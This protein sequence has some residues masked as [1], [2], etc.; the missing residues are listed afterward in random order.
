M[1]NIVKGT[2]SAYDGLSRKTSTSVYFTIDTRKI[3]IGTYLLLK[4][5]VFKYFT[6][7]KEDSI[8]ITIVGINGITIIDLNDFQAVQDFQKT[9]ESALVYAYR[10][11][12]FITVESITSDLLISE[13]FRNAYCVYYGFKVG[14]EEGDISSTLF[15]DSVNG[16]TYPAN[17]SIAVINDGTLEN[18]IYKF[19]VL[20]EE[21]GSS[22]GGSGD[23]IPIV[24]DAV[25]GDI[26]I[27]N[28]NGGISDS[29][30]T[31][32]VS[33]PADAVFSKE[34]FVCNYDH[35]HNTMDKTISEINTARS[36]GMTVICNYGDNTYYYMYG[37]STSCVFRTILNL[38]NSMS[39]NYLK[40]VNGA[41]STG[42]ESW[43]SKAN[44]VANA[45][46]GH[47]AGL[48]SNGYLTD[49]GYSPSDFQ[50]PSD[51]PRV[52]IPSIDGTYVQMT[53]DEIAGLRIGDII[54]HC[55]ENYN[56]NLDLY[57]DFYVSR[58]IEN[59][60]IEAVYVD[61]A[62]IIRL[63]FSKNS[64]NVWYYD[65]SWTVTLSLLAHKV[66]N[67]TTGNFASLDSNGDLAD[68]GYAALDFLTSQ[69]I[70]GKEDISNKVISLSSS[71]TDTEYPSAKCVYDLVG[72]IETLLALI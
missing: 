7:D 26:A 55:D 67:P 56:G 54:R 15:I 38:N 6:I 35:D 12:G 34:V 14:S 30:M 68:S 52:I 40:Y 49:S 13:N 60:I 25:V 21:S 58:I 37:S 1:I 51:V 33:V 28:S 46:S 4:G 47:L 71:S 53:S 70:S 44:K 10:P 66:T 23:Y 39:F 11:A 20:S 31:I 8:V 18:P 2:Q 32:G 22:G 62:E 45:V 27:F 50:V 41:W 64:S 36:N 48:D 72:D 3:Y 61:I 29:G 17:T 19:T 5:D 63:R 16:N 65:R 57:R 43:S 24:D 42:Q 9:V 69:D 59:S